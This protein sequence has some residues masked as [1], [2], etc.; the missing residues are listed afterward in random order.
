MR[1]KSVVNEN[2][3]LLAE[4][5]FWTEEAKKRAEQDDALAPPV[6]SGGVLGSDLG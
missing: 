6:L 3:R 2:E 4:V 5:K 1:T